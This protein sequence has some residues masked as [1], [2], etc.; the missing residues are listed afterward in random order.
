MANTNSQRVAAFLLALMFL[1]TTVGA[2]GYVI[3]QLNNEDAGLVNDIALEQPE[4][5]PVDDQTDT[6]IENFTG[7]YEVPEL[8]FEDT[9]VGDGE[10]VVASDTVTIHYTG[11][12]AT[13]GVVFDSSVTRGEPATFPLDNLIAG[14][15]QGIP[16]MKVGGKRRLFIP[17]DLGYGASG[18]G[19]SIPPNTDLIFDIELFDTTR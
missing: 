15:Q 13:T 7:P 11:A 8:R 12:L 18:S 10:A 4:E 3:Y 14:W 17:S 19:S 16:G 2:A 5:A 6:V 9:V 1:L